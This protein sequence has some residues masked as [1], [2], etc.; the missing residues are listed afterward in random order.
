VYER[1]DTLLLGRTTWEIWAAYWPHHDDG[2]PVS[3][4]I[5]V[6]PSACRRPRSRDPAWQNTHVIDGDV[7]AAARELKAKPGRGNVGE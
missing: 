6:L 7:E 2:G 5:N 1:A 3:H 4:G